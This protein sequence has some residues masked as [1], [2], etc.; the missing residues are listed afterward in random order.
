MSNYSRLYL[1]LCIFYFIVLSPFV[2]LHHSSVLFF[3]LTLFAVC[4]LRFLLIYFQS[5]NNRT[6][7][8]IS[9]PIFRFAYKV[10]VLIIFG[11]V[12]YLHGEFRGLETGMSLLSVLA[13]L[14]LIESSKNR[15]FLTFIMITM[16]LFM[17]QLLSTDSLWVVGYILFVVTFLFY[18]MTQIK[19]TFDNVQDVGIPSSSFNFKKTAILVLLT[20]PLT[21]ILF[22]IFPRISIGNV[23]T[24]TQ[25]TTGITGFSHR[26]RPGEVSELVSNPQLVFR[27]IFETEDGVDQ[28]GLSLSDLYWRGRV[29]IKN[30]GLNWDPAPSL[31]RESF[32][33]GR[34]HSLSS[35]NMIMDDEDIVRFNYRISMANLEDSPI[36]HLDRT[37]YFRSVGPGRIFEWEGDTFRFVPLNNQRGNFLL[38]SFYQAT[39]IISGPRTQGLE[40]GD[41]KSYTQFPYDAIDGTRFVSFFKEIKERLEIQK[42]NLSS[43]QIKDLSLEIMNDFQERGFSYTLSP[44]VY[45]SRDLLGGIEEFFFERKIG[46]CEH[47]AAAFA[48]ILRYF[49]IPSRVVVGFHGGE[50]NDIGNHYLVSSR[51]AHAWVEYWDEEK[52]GWVRFDPTAYIAPSRIE[53]GTEYFLL[54]LQFPNNE[55]DD[56]YH[57]LQFSVFRRFRYQFDFYYFQLNQKFLSYDLASQLSI[58]RS[59]GFNFPDTLEGRRKLISILLVFSGLFLGVFGALVYL[60]RARIFQFWF[61]IFSESKSPSLKLLVAYQNLLYRFDSTCST[62]TT[63]LSPMEFFDKAKGHVEDKEY[64]FDALKELDLLLYDPSI[65]NADYSRRARLLEHKI[66]RINFRFFKD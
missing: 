50:F 4:I 17:A 3:S 42:G 64:L 46:F 32:S 59:L 26:L 38:S 2:G 54:G 1:K 39:N 65:R 15:D 16:F 30:N 66:S 44:G 29:L 58:L 21:S 43:E 28:R 41:F 27:A 53:R 20:L 25:T 9:H 61:W 34:S 13:P 6:I 47:Y 10:M 24:G 37:Y 56:I 48:F 60:L 33:L 5:E 8:F 40:A 18:L 52:L 55:I 35:Y 49:G 7:A 23:F 22:F 11:G 45:D 63:N 12:V 14:K 36:F 31:P 51:D 19:D 57:N 62:S